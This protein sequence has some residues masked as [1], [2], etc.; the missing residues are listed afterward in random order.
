[1]FSSVQLVTQ[2]CLT[3]CDP[4]DCN[5]PG[6]PVHHQL[7]ELTQTH[8][9][10]GGDAI[11]P[12]HPLSSASPPAFNLSQ[13][14]GLFQWDP[15]FR[16][17]GQSI[18]VSA[19][20]S[21]VPMNI[22]DWFP[23]GWTGWISL[24]SK[25]RSRVFFNTTVQKHQF[26]SA[27][28]IIV[29]LSHPYM[30]TGKT[31]ALT[32]WTFVGKV[33]SLLFNMLS[34]TAAKSLQLCPTLCDPIDSCPP[35]SAIFGILQARTLGWVAITFSSEWKWKVKVKSLSHVQLFETPWTVA[36]QAPLS[37]GFPRQEYWS[38]YTAY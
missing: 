7:P 21:V 6:F 27:H 30:S 28:I 4:M 16:S 26:F 37:M 19:S 14:Q 32:R 9:L 3:L 31:I 5:T 13:H 2:L 29:H 25:G 11:Q 15:F 22:Q 17:G 35:G 1:M 12:Y 10:W 24:Q 18:G 34:A 20:T 23:L 38:S 33:M 36:Y 8:V